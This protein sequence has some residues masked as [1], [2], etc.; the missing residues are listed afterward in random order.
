MT[1]HG[2]TSLVMAWT[3][4]RLR[5]DMETPGPQS[6]EQYTYDH[7]DHG[8]YPNVIGIND[9]GSSYT[10]YGCEKCGMAFTLKWPKF[11]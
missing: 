10:D 11:G 1:D 9:D 7:C 8:I 2:N 5:D 6:L 4:S 3:K